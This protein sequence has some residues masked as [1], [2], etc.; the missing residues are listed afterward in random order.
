MKRA[1][2][3]LLMIWM[4]ILLMLMPS[5][6]AA[7]SETKGNS[8][9]RID[10]ANVYEK[11]DKSYSRGYSPSVQKDFVTLVLPL[12]ASESIQQDQ[13]HVTFD[14]GDP[15]SSP[16]QFQNYD[17]TVKLKSH[18][19]NDNGKQ[20]DSFLVLV[21]IPLVEDPLNGRYPVII[22]A[23]GQWAD[24]TSFSQEFT[25]YVTVS[26]GIAP[27]EAPTPDLSE[28]EPPLDEDVISGV[29]QTSGS[30]A[31][32]AEVTEEPAKSQAKIL[33]EQCSVNPSPVTPGEEFHITATF[34]NTNESQSLE[35]VKIT[36]TGEVAD[37]IPAGEGT[38]SFY[39]EKIPGKEAVTIDMK[40]K[41]A[42]NAKAEPHKI[43]FA[44][45]YEGN[46]GTAYTAEEGTIVQITQPVRLEFDEPQIAKEVNAG[47]TIAVST[48]V[49]NLGLSTVHNVR[50]T[51][52]AEGLL[53]EET[54]FIGNIESGAAKKGDL[55]VFVK[56]LNDG[57]GTAANKEQYGITEGKV[58]LTYED[59]Y[60]REYTKEFEFSTTIN[61]PVIMASDDAEEEN[62]KPK[63][64]GQWWTSILLIAGITV[65]IIGIYTY[66]KRRQ[67]RIRRQEED[68]TI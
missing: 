22:R 37:I 9:L 32:S 42:A 18:S 29:D 19:V 24:G 34:R 39:F 48:N 6:I 12:V 15:A 68:D 51:V 56:T 66:R 55:Y 45:E 44:V 60:Q 36:A 10:N 7:S 49:M 54:A 52:E 16:F 43:K 28:T 59:E 30:E 46:K 67:E 31:A 53:P 23:T 27:D 63:N 50:M 65:L 62:Q 1:K 64:Q 40:M 33:L 38:G 11:M 41:A 4:V 3:T 8:L 5:T 58:L 26:E 14:L 47:D 57:T 20:T 61:P 13:I 25:L 2:R 35:N 21:N 17:K